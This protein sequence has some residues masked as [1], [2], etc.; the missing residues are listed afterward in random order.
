M[1]VIVGMSQSLLRLTNL[2]QPMHTHNSICWL[3]PSNQRQ[4][5]HLYRE[6]HSSQ[7]SR[8]RAKS[9]TLTPSGL[10][11]HAPRSSYHRVFGFGGMERWNGMVEWTALERWSGTEH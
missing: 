3:L 1:Y 4:S 5:G 7:V 11:S 10:H 8:L 6:H 9:H 2:Y